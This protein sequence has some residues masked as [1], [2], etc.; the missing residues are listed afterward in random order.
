MPADHCRGGDRSDAAQSRQPVGRIAAEQREVAVAPPGNLVAA[1][2]LGLVDD[3][4]TRLLRIQ[5]AD[6]RVLDEGEQIAIAARDLDAP[7]GARGERRDHVLSLVVRHADDVHS[8]RGENA[9]DHRDLWHQ[10][11]RDRLGGAVLLVARQLLDAPL[12]S[13]V[14]VVGDGDPGR[15]ALAD[16]PRETVEEGAD[17]RCPQRVGIRDAALNTVVGTEDEARSIDEQPVA[18]HLADSG[19]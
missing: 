19:G 15:P 7:R 9:V 2:D 13:P 8:D 17:R 11:R 6:A 5:H 14:G 10:P 3:G 4:Q 16:Q 18:G 12:R 1:G